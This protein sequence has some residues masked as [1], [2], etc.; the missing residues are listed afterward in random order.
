MIRRLQQLGMSAERHVVLVGV[1]STAVLAFVVVAVYSGAY[2]K[3][4]AADTTTVRAVF[5]DTAQ[6][7]KSDPVRVKGVNVGT[8]SDITLDGD[9]RTATVTMKVDETAAPI[10][11]DATATLRWRTVLGG[12]FAVDL[13]RGSSTAGTLTGPIPAVRTEGQVELDDVLASVR[14]PQ[15]AGLQSLLHELPQVFA[16]PAAPATAL[17]TL[18]A[19]APDL[20]KALAAARGRSDGDLPALVRNTAAAVRAVNTPGDAIRDVVQGGATTLTTTGNRA[21]DIGQAID[22]LADIT[23]R[24]RATLTRLDTT[25][26]G[27]DGLADD[28]DAPAGQLAPAVA[29]LRPVVRRAEPLLRDVRPLVRR[30]RPAVRSLVVTARAG[31]PVIEDL[32]P[33]VDRVRDTILPFL[34]ERDA[35]SKRTTYE[36]IGPTFASTNSAMA[37]YDKSSSL[38]RFPLFAQGTAIDSLPCGEIITDPEKSAVL[39]CENLMSS[40]KQLSGY[41]P[42][43]PVPGSVNP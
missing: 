40:I 39:Q 6:L 28:L 42:L 34:A 13:D 41:N 12:T 10:Y 37:G 19:S 27:V 26:T 35:V 36:M 29:R 22:L 21:G 7:T 17:D 31:T 33:S 24:V 3:P 25:L 15:R 2:R 18:A 16:D 38:F 14:G 23:P 1:V 43:G 11:A 4:F 8:V 9:G 32:T 20:R 5:T 30:L